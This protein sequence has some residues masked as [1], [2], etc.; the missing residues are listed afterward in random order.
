MKGVIELQARAKRLCTKSCHIPCE[1]QFSL[2]VYDDTTVQMLEVRSHYVYETVREDKVLVKIHM[3]LLSI[4]SDD[5]IRHELS[6]RAKVS[7]AADPCA[8][9]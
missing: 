2:L 6:I 4:R 5:D 8:F 3:T 9:R 1:S 7:T